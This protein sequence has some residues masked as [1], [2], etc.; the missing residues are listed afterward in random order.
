MQLLAAGMLT[1]YEQHIL[2]PHWKNV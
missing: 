2:K 1:D